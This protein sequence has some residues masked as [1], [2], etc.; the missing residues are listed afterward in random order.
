LIGAVAARYIAKAI[1]D[2]ACCLPS[3]AAAADAL[4]AEA[5]WEKCY[6]DAEMMPV[7]RPLEGS[8]AVVDEG[9]AKGVVK[10]GWLSTAAGDRLR[11]SPLPLP[12]GPCGLLRVQLSYLVSAY[13]AGMGA[14]KIGCTGC[15]CMP[16]TSAFPSLYPFPVVETDT[17]RSDDKHLRQSNVSI[18]V[19]TEFQ[20][21]WNRS[22]STPCAV[23][24]MHLH[25]THRAGLEGRSRIR[26]DAMALDALEG[27]WLNYMISRGTGSVRRYA[28]MARQC[29]SVAN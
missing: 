17:H 29:A 22:S 28:H 2:A 26:I 7:L 3:Q 19:S 16:V 15:S 20:A 24:I 18:T 1:A 9:K 5:D 27:V 21:W 6:E 25:R 23:D 14:F 11:L 8:W 12:P 10:R 4:P 13:V